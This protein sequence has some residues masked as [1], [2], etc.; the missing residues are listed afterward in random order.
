[1]DSFCVDYFIRISLIA[2]L[3][4]LFTR[5]NE[6]SQCEDLCRLQGNVSGASDVDILAAA[7][8]ILRKRLV[9]RTTFSLVKVKANRG[10]TANKRAK[11]GKEW[12]Q[13]ASRAQ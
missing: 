6:S 5:V 7:I 3:E 4:S 11:V 8:K 9:M 2:L 13:W 1:V 12:C 10:Q